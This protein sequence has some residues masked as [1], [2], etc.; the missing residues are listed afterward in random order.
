MTHVLQLFDV[1]LAS[2]LKKRFA[3]LFHDMMK[4]ESNHVD[5]NVAATMR[6]NTIEAFTTAWDVICSKAN[7]ESAAAEVG[8]HPVDRSR[9]KS[10]PYV[11]DLT[12]IE[13]TQLAA[14][15]RKHSNRISISGCLLSG[16]TKID[17]VRGMVGKNPRDKDL[18]GTLAE[19]EGYLPFLKAILTQATTNG[20]RLL[21]PIP[22]IGITRIT[23]DKNKFFLLYL[24]YVLSLSL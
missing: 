4:K 7:C 21:S 13:R 3:Q 22:P 19:Y 10:S 1:G 5:G 20:T 2:P 9:P 16:T 8:L 18:A 15:N 24:M 23:V 17:E 6:K 12:E 11:R 14:W